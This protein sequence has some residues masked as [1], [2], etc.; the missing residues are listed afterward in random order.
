[1]ALLGENKLL[2]KDTYLAGGS[3]L[4]LIFGHRISTDFDFFT[5]NEF[6]PEEIAKKLMDIGKFETDKITKITLLGSF[7]TVRFSLF[8]YEYPLLFPP[9]NFNNINIASGKDIAAMKIAAIMDRG[10]QKDFFDLYFLSQ[11][12]PLDHYLE[13]YDRKYKAL[14]NNI[15]SIITS[16]TYFDEAETS[17]KPVLLTDIDWKEVKEFFEKEAKILAKKYL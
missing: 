3:A 2:P 17:E 13:Y 12:E 5:P 10:T 4:A 7:E 15:Y 14:A 1:L 9:S 16:L 11:K 8:R 6:N